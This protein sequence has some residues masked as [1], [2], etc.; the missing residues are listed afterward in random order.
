MEKI[1]LGAQ[2]A[3]YPSLTVLV[4]ST[5]RGKPN[6]NTI[7]HVGICD[8]ERISLGMGKVHFSN[9][10]IKENGCFSV[11]VPSQDLVEKTDFCGIASGRKIDKAGQFEVFYGTL[12]RAPMIAECPVCME[13]RLERV[14]DFPRHDLFVGEIVATYA[15]A[16]VLDRRPHRLRQGAA[17]ALRH[18]EPRLLDARRAHRRRLGDRQGP[19][20]G[21]TRRAGQLELS[22][23]R[24]SPSAC[25][26]ARQIEGG[27]MDYASLGDRSLRGLDPA[28][29]RSWCVHPQ[30][31]ETLSPSRGTAE[32]SVS[33]QPQSHPGGSASTCR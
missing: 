2:L 7:A 1:D 21:L 16:A 24:P 8:M 25:R 15:D 9:A 29:D 19:Q 33:A 10:G 12:D 13:C 22:P 30:P 23:S 18:A 17:A 26:P 28:A 3:L 11:N 20:A 27:G 5:V 31:D 6:F 4:G 32:A 14:V